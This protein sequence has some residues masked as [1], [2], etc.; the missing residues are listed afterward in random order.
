M[1]FGRM[2]IGVLF[3]YGGRYISFGS[4]LN[5]IRALE[6]QSVSQRTKWYVY[7]CSIGCLLMSWE[8]EGGRWQ[9]GPICKQRR[10]SWT[11]LIPIA[12]HVTV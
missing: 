6:R 10:N 7:A 4:D 3:S 12:C 9:T 11:Q 8:H 5:A 2:E 1:G